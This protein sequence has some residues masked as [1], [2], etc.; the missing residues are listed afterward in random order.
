MRYD[1]HIFI[2][3]NQKAPGKACC[4]EEHG[5][6]LVAKFREVIEERGLKGKVRAQRSGCL[7]ACKHGPS[8]VI[9]PEGTYYGKVG[10]NDVER[11]IDNHVIGGNLIEALEINWD[12]I[13]QKS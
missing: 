2:C 11:I 6:A 13:E 12:A 10:M 3:T 8:L 5:L 7:D 9:Y 4:G 1:K